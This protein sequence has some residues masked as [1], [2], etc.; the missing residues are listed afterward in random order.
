MLRKKIVL[1]LSVL[2]FFSFF[3]GY[4]Y[5][6]DITAASAVV[7]DAGTGSVL[8][9]KCPR[10]KRSM[11][12]TTKIM[13]ALLAI[14]S[15]RLNDKVRITDEMVRVEGSSMGLRSGN[16]LTLGNLI[17]GMLLLSGND[18]ANSVA[19]FLSGS[20]EKFAVLMNEKA[21]EIGMRDTHFVTPSGL[22]SEEHYT[23]AYD[24]ALLASYAMKY[25][26]FSAIVSEYSG[27][28]EFIEPD[29]TYTYKN[30]N[31]FLNMYDGA[32]GIKTGFTKKSGRCL[33]TAVKRNGT[34]LIA[35]TLKATDYWE[36][37][38]KL[39]DYVLSTSECREIEDSFET[40]VKV[41]GSDVSEVRCSIKEKPKITVFKDSVITTEVLTE[42]F[43]YA[44][45]SRGE[46]VGE[47]RLCVN[48]K[49]V[50]SFPLISE[51]D[52]PVKA[53]DN[54]SRNIFSRVFDFLIKNCS[55]SM[56][57]KERHCRYNYVRKYS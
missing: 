12:S 13:T 2:V 19:V 49:C 22:D 54:K 23:T 18:A 51:E 53:S 7:V 50:K 16:E 36:D 32:C 48:G 37:H 10:E 15:G 5:A 56:N 30:H 21:R 42:K 55:V 35:V 29:C 27:K 34:M 38:R 3:N 9:E 14:E 41:T 28:V 57:V 20:N 40:L 52:A 45:V 43:V 25:P 6:V 46:T 4:A 33:I 8:Y 11:A 31:R 44:P 47:V 1:I 17:K 39:Y 26:E 24:M